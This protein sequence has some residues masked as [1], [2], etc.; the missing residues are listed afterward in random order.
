MPGD[1]LRLVQTTIKKTKLQRSTPGWTNFGL[2]SQFLTKIVRPNMGVELLT[3]RHRPTDSKGKP[4]TFQDGKVRISFT[5]KYVA[6][7][8]AGKGEEKEYDQIWET[9]ISVARRCLCKGTAKDKLVLD[10]VHYGESQDFRKK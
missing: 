3:H 5:P 2:E 8:G 4:Y 6:A 1:S 10:S 9:H 7:G